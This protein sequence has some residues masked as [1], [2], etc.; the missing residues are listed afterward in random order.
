MRRDLEDM[1]E[2][3]GAFL[4]Q[5]PP[6]VLS[7]LHVRHQLAPVLQLPQ[8]GREPQPHRS[9]HRAA[10]SFNLLAYIPGYAIGMVVGGDAGRREMLKVVA[11]VLAVGLAGPAV[12]QGYYGSGSNS[13]S[14]GVQGYTRSD[15]SYVQPHHRTNPNSTQMD[16]YGTRGNSNPYTGAYGT[17]SPRY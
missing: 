14:H 9:H 6:H 12:A 5:P 8:R 13:S 10:S 2:Y 11:F 7:R 3:R 1:T 16:N 17:R 15:G 4:R